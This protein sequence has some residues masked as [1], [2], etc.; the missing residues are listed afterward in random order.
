MTRRLPDRVASLV[1]SPVLVLAFLSVLAGC[2]DM[3]GDA[4]AG[5]PSAGPV[6]T[7]TPEP[8]P[9][10]SPSSPTSASPS[11]SPGDSPSESPGASPTESP[12]GSP[13]E[14][15]STS[16]T[17]SQPAGPT[18]SGPSDALPIGSLTEALLTADELPGLNQE[19]RWVQGRTRSREPRRL[20]GTCHRFDL[21]SI[22]ADQVAHRGFRAPRGANAVAG[23]L[24][25]EFADRKTAWRAYRTMLAWRDSCREKLRSYPRSTVGRLQD[26]EV[27]RGR[28]GWYLLTYG[29]IGDDPDVAAF[30]AQGLTRVGNRVAVTRMT[31]YGQ[32]YNYERGSEPMVEAVRRAAASLG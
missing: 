17:A 11:E 26:V 28:A 20:A 16:P 25:A 7:A 6:E 14:P 24:V 23:E 21:L 18:A 30:D 8:S 27:D 15:E 29:P 1:V 32:D 3:S 19:F 31:V 5:R 2:G 4:E 10:P 9:E 12:T 13:T 22:G